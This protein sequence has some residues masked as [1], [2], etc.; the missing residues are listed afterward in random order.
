MATDAATSALPKYGHRFLTPEITTR[1][2]D[3][4]DV[5][6]VT[7]SIIL[8]PER[9]GSDRLMLRVVAAVSLVEPTGAGALKKFDLG[10]LTIA[11]HNPDS[12]GLRL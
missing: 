10:N 4:S 2:D 1:T 7:R 6:A 5:G 3:A 11:S 12:R 9:A 8:Y